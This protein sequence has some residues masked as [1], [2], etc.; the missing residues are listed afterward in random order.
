MADIKKDKVPQIMYDEF[1]NQLSKKK[2]KKIK[3]WEMAR[4][5]RVGDTMID[6]P[7]I[8]T[9][10]HTSMKDVFIDHLRFEKNTDE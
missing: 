7:T 9:R 3:A 4:L 1:G 8:R 6:H 2:M 10:F 5:N